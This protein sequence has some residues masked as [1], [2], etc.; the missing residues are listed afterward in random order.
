[1]AKYRLLTEIQI[2]IYR[3]ARGK[4]NKIATT[5]YSQP[6]RCISNKV[7]CPLSPPSSSPPPQPTHPRH[8]GRGPVKRSTLDY[9]YYTHCFQWYM[10]CNQNYITGQWLVVFPL[11]HTLYQNCKTVNN[12]KRD[13]CGGI[14]TNFLQS[15][16]KVML[17]CGS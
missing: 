12:I 14:L 13:H 15:P 3:N 17:L 4:N 2:S 7:I 6:K 8:E 10:W 16:Y 9:Y 1:M 5:T 11:P